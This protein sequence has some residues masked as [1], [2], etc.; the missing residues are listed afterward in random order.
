VSRSL[1][2][3]KK[4]TNLYLTEQNYCTSYNVIT[5]IAEVFSA[6]SNATHFFF[7]YSQFLF[8]F[9]VVFVAISENFSKT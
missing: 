1:Y 3:V 6:V 5:Y 9:C 8:H 4:R 7:I 2:G